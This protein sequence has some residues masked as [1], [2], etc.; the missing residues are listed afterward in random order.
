MIPAEIDCYKLL[1][2]STNVSYTA[3]R[4]LAARKVV[5]I[6]KEIEGIDYATSA[7][8]KWYFMEDV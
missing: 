6:L 1:S 5:H 2:I 3:R 8:C 4:K 7:F